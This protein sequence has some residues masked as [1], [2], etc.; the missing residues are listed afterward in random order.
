M[1][2][3]HAD[4]FLHR[5]DGTHRDAAPNFH[6]PELAAFEQHIREHTADGHTHP[7]PA[8]REP[9]AALADLDQ[10]NHLD[11]DHNV[12]ASDTLA[13]L[14]RADRTTAHSR[15]H[16]AGANHRHRGAEDLTPD[17]PAGRTIDKLA[18]ALLVMVL[19]PDHHR[20]MLA[21]DPQALSQAAEALKAA[22]RLDRE[23]WIAAALEAQRPEEA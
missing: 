4:P 8:G 13:L 3:H 23:A 22:D 21:N 16:A 5:A 17:Q 6:G 14:T 10:V 11:F 9:F 7:A 2:D 20:W 1:T 15:A 18:D 12:R 19:H